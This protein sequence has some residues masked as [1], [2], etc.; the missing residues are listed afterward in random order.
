MKRHSLNLG[1]I[2]CLSMA[3]Y[4][5]YLLLLDNV[6]PCSIGAIVASISHLPQHWHILAVA[7]MPVYIAFMIVVAGVAGL[8]FGNKLQKLIS[9]FCYSKASTVIRCKNDA[10]HVVG[11]CPFQARSKIR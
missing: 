8:F 10:I 5:L 7:L 9:K 1:T 6:F 11:K 2:I 4:G 3:F